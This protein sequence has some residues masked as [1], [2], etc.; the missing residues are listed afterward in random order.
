MKGILKKEGALF[1]VAGPCS[2]ESEEQLLSTAKLLK[3]SGRVSLFRAGVWKPRTR[4]D[5]FEG[6]GERALPWLTRVKE[7]TGFPVAVEVANAGHVELVLK[8]G[9]DALWLGA[10][11]TANPFSVQEI[12]DSLRGV[13]IPVMIKNPINVDLSLWIGAIERIHNVGLTDIM[14]IHR[15]FATGE[16][17]QYRNR[18]VWRIP[19]EL[20]HHFPEL[21][22][23]CDPSHISG[24]R[25][26]I[27]E[28]CQKA[29]DRGMNGLMVEVHCR[30]DEA[31]SDSRQ[32][33]TPENF[34]QIVE[35]LQL[36]REHPTD[37]V[38]EKEIELLR[39]KLGTVDQELLKVLK[40]RM[41]IVDEIGILKKKNNVTA[42]QVA[43]MNEML[44]EYREQAENINLEKDY[45]EEVYNVIHNQSVKR[46]TWIF[47]KSQTN[48]QDGAPLH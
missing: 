20:K 45:V 25:S 29:L 47:N 23:I 39:D 38:F 37:I 16:V 5:S 22:V 27:P 41:D 19:I 43:R 31:L 7:E 1:V 33:I 2:A 42:F 35:G 34:C 10:R 9:V 28:I 18:P 14:A 11:T 44:E 36:K 26:L 6:M 13:S 32:Q 12:A 21:P 17:N 46:Q 48:L 4:P 24:K 8:H 15:G 3:A 30:P 40:M